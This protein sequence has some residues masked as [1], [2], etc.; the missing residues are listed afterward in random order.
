MGDIPNWHESAG[1]VEA[2]LLAAGG[3]VRPSDDLRPRV[4]ETARLQRRE[5]RA[6]R[7]IRRAAAA[8]VL[9]AVFTASVAHQATSRS[10]GG[11][12]DLMAADS[13]A[14]HD[15]AAMRAASAGGISWGLVDAFSELK[16]EQSE[17][18][19]PGM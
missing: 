6:R 2:M 1:E 4:L 11:K 19:R 15:R 18:I 13:Q 9:L 12:F 3:Y 7:L 16:Q 17:A 5:L 8:V 10:A 14:M